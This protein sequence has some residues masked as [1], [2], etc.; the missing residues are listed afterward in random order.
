[1]SNKIPYKTYLS[2]QEMPKHW[3]NLKAFMKEQHAPFLNPSTGAPCTAEDLEAVFCKECVSQE[4]NATDRE[5]E[6]PKEIRDFYQMFRPSPLVRAYFL[7]R[8]LD[9]PAEIYY[10]FEGN[11]TSGSHFSDCISTFIW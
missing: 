3:L 7:E 8:V 6:I 10:K 2:E 4:L 11:N 5:I 1:M 9:T